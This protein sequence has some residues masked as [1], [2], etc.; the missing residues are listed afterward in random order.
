MLG[1][2]KNASP[3]LACSATKANMEAG[4]TNKITLKAEIACRIGVQSAGEKNV[5]F[6]HDVVRSSV[7]SSSPA[8]NVPLT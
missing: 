1:S 6:T 3:I 4:R 2:G 5:I 8:P 7:K